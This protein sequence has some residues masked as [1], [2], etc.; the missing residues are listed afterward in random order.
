MKPKDKNMHG[1]ES[2]RPVVG[3]DLGTTNSAVAHIKS[4]HPEI[5]SSPEGEKLIPSVVHINSQG[6]VIVGQ[7]AADALVAMPSRT[8]AAIKRKMGS[9]QPI[10]IAH[11]DLLP[12]E[13]SSLIL[14]ELKG[15]LDQCYGEGEKEAVITVPAYFTDQ[16]RRATRRAGELAGLVVERIINEPT[17]AGLAFGLEHLE[18]ESHILVYDLGGGT[19]DVSVLELMN[20]LL[21]VKASTG[22]NLLG[23]EDFDWRLVDYMAEKMINKYDIDPRDDL[24]ARALLKEEAEK[25]KI[26]LS[27]KESV[28]ISLPIVTVKDNQPLGLDLELSRSDFIDLI[29]DLLQQTMGSIEEVLDGAELDAEEIDEIILVGGSTYIPR[30]HELIY[31]FFN[32]H[33]RTDVNPEEAVAL[34]AA[35]QAGLKSGVLSDSGLIAT[36]I[37]PYSMGV[38]VLRGWMGLTHR[39]GGFHAII[40]KN[41]TIPTTRTER[42]TTVSNDQTE[43]S[44]EIYQG[45]D[46]WTKNNHQL[47]EF[48]LEGLPPRKAGEEEVDVTFRYNLNG[49]LEVT[50][51]SV[52]TGKAMTI[53]VQDALDRN[54]EESYQK[55]LERLDSFLEEAAQQSSKEEEEEWRAFK[56]MMEEM[57]LPDIDDELE[58]DLSNEANLMLSRAKSTLK[59]AAPEEKEDL[60]KI[61]DLLEQGL[62]DES[63]L[64]WAVNEATDI[65]IELETEGLEDNDQ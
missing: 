23:G 31:N 48:L 42:F 35:V 58:E 54:S 65:F 60:R 18:D 61:I 19:F 20:G 57:D 1:K 7:A 46:Q 41:T 49:I 15:Y 62:E 50:A 22:D 17:A 11:Q 30:I 4:G 24:R 53:S 28:A 32:R 44:I 34:G 16:Q 37:A 2:F 64:E 10:S 21:E 6:E 26:S 43:V 39:P 29:E 38:A 56:K 52:S 27:N 45:E 47:G 13:I 40:P 8:V 51:E 25:A 9:E 3:I 14:K 59:M 36:D 12:E 63:R 33:P 5:I 55:S